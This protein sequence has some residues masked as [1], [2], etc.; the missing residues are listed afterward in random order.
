MIS[1]EPNK[2]KRV[3]RCLSTIVGI[4]GVLLMWPVPM[5]IY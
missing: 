5:Q 4:E 3:P 2:S 1:R